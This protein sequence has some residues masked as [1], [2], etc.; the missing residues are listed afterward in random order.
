LIQKNERKIMARMT[1]EEAD[2]LDEL[3]TKN[4]PK[5]SG[6]GKS[7]FFMKHKGNI[8]ILDDVCATWLRVR[9]ESTRK[10]AAELI[11]E[12]IREKIAVAL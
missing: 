6:D 4:P 7:G 5:V 1:D 12:I 2:A 9:S 8:V 3:V 11:S 10:S